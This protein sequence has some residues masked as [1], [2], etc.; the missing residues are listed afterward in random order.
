[1]YLSNISLMADTS[2]IR[3]NYFCL[4]QRIADKD[5]ISKIFEKYILA[6]INSFRYT[7]YEVTGYVFFSHHAICLLPGC[8]GR[9]VPHCWIHR[10]P[11]RA[12][13]PSPSPTSGNAAQ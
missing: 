11:A 1:M 2:A 3:W 6:V 7:Y 8:V 9:A 10:P 12:G 13:A 4:F 5:V